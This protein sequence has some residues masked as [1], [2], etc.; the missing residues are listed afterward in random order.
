MKRRKRLLALKI[1]SDKKKNKNK[2]KK[3]LLEMSLMMLDKTLD[4]A[5]EEIFL[6]KDIRRQLLKRS[7]ELLTTMLKSQK[8]NQRL[9]LC[10]KRE[11][12]L[13]QM[14]ISQNQD[15]LHLKSH[16]T[17]RFNKEQRV[18]QLLDQRNRI[19]ERKHQLKEMDQTRT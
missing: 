3:L 13:M 16:Q 8:L 2:K 19:L 7:Q 18:L 9:N 5:I 4:Q 10:I 15:N 12:D 17:K 6:L 11:K 1:N 14:T